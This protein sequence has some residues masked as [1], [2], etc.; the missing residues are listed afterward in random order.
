MLGSR[1]PVAESHGCPYITRE[2]EAHKMGRGR[3][4][5]ML[6]AVTMLQRAM[7]RR[8]RVQAS[9]QTSSSYSP[10]VVAVS[11]LATVQI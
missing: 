5:L 3:P 2:Q 6:E 7:P 4:V 11:C 1:V 8:I 10:L 9:L